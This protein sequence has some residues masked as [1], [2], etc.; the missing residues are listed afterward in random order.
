MKTA[1]S[2]IVKAVVIAAA[3]ASSAMA[4]VDGT[5]HDLTAVA[6][7]EVCHYCHVPHGAMANTPL[8]GHKLSNAVYK[9]YQSTSLVA[10]VGQPTGSSKLCLS[11][12]DGTIAIASTVT[13]GAGGMYISPGEK[14]LGTDLSDDHPI[15]FTYS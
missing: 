1:V 9:I 4:M 14:N 5:P 7:G 11:C 3:F 13:G 12:H 2:E 6:G 8:W 10:K 15:S